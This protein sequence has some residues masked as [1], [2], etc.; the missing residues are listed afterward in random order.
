MNRF[1][2]LAIGAGVALVNVSST[3]IQA[4]KPERCTGVCGSCGLSCAEPIVGLVGI[5]IVAVLWGKF[6][7]KFKKLKFNN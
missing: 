5:G 2:S 1:K 6:K 3:F 7:G 4:F